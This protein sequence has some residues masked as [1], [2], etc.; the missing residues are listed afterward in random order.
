MAPPSKLRAL[1]TERI[2]QVGQLFRCT[3][4]IGNNAQPLGLMSA[5]RLVEHVNRQGGQHQRRI[6][7][8][9]AH[10]RTTDDTTETKNDLP[11]SQPAPP[12]DSQPQVARIPEAEPLAPPL[13]LLPSGEWSNAVPI[14]PYDFFQDNAYDTSTNLDA[15]TNSFPTTQ[16]T[17]PSPDAASVSATS[18]LRA[19]GARSSTEANLYDDTLWCPYTSKP[20]FL[21]HSLFN[22]PAITFS[23][24]QKAAILSWANEMGTD[25]VPTLHELDQCDKK[26]KDILGDELACTML[27]Q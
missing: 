25:N 24:A 3:V 27:K 13:I 19:T 17:L 18:R 5:S 21:T 9:A 6:Q 1:P 14:P 23:E 8:A 7:Q 4:C 2:V 16:F 22:A 20:L 15:L 10:S 26:I 11:D 12:S